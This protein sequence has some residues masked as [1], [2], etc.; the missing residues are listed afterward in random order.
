MTSHE[1]DAMLAEMRGGHFYHS[2]KAEQ[3]HQALR[4]AAA[5]AVVAA[6]SL[7]IGIFAI[8]TQWDRIAA[9]VGCCGA[10]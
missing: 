10:A 1:Y 5:V 9:A 8:A 3:A 6:G 2:L 4:D 7:M